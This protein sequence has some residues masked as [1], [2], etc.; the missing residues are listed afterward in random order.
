MAQQDEAPTDIPPIAEPLAPYI[1]TRQEALRIRQVLTAY[2]RSQI[3][4]KDNDPNLPNSH[5]QSH[6]SLCVPNESVVDVKPI[7]PEITGLRRQYLEALQANVAARKEYRDI[8]EQIASAR[9]Q[10]QDRKE[11]PAHDPNSDFQAYLKLLR[12][13]RHHAKLQV[14]Q[15]HLD[16]LKQRDV[17]G[18]EYF[19][20]QTATDKHIAPPELDGSESEGGSKDNLEELVHKL[21]R[22]VIRAKSQLDREKKLLE[23]VKARHESNGPREEDIPSAVK[24]RALQRTRDE[25]VQWIEKQLVITGG[26]DSGPV[27]E[28]SPEELEDS[29]R[30][31]E[32]RKEQIQKQYDIY[33]AARKK[34]LDAAS[35][36]CQPIAMTPAPMPSTQPRITEQKTLPNE[37]PSIHPIDALA[38][39]SENILPL[40][41]SQRALALQKSYLSGMLAK[42]KATTLRRL[43]RLSDESH[44]LPE[45]PIP[46][47]QS[48]FRNA[49]ALKHRRTTS[50]A[51]P[52]KPD[53]VVRLAEAWAFASEA[54][55]EKER[56]HVEQQI[57][58]GDEAAQDAQ[59]T[60]QEVYDILNQDLEVTQ[61]DQGPKGDVWADEARSTPS[62]MKAGRDEKRLKGPWSRLNG[63]VDID[64]TI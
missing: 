38:F 20:K 25:L 14:F 41:K 29:A 32:E 33:I 54:A 17:P 35:K 63:Q 37:T 26:G 61:G 8:S 51:E 13:R 30:L 57:E 15:H 3:V 12:G 36:A 23:E 19:E 5:A 18:S 16:E 58:L 31:L 34:L 44:L 60:L 40:A 2:L 42:E 55:G 64:D 7:P 46:D 21:E 27:V 28:L 49:T 39:T 56:Q 50:S 1:K 9:L 45:Y 43:N 6:L 24:A 48:R 47:R 62:Q 53:E 22:A 59:K 11:A 10:Q 4:F 52:T